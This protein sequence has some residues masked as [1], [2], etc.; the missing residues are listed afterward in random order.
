MGRL[1][2]L[3][4]QVAAVETYCR[5]NGFTPKYFHTDVT[6]KYEYSILSRVKWE[7]HCRYELKEVS[8]PYFEYVPL[9]IVNQNTRFTPPTYLQSEKYFDESIARELYAIPRGLVSYITRRYPDIHD[10]ISLHVRR[11]DYV[12]QPNYH[13]TCPLEYYRK[14]AELFPNQ[15]F[16]VFSDDHDWCRKNLTGIDW[17]FG[18]GYTDDEELYMMSLCKGHIIANSTFSW[19]GAYLNPEKDKLVVAPNTWFGPSYNNINTKDLIPE[20]WIKV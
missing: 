8:H 6:P 20:S 15:K 1:G 16:L 14:A 3:L 12:R 18:V 2:N 19:W 10:R 4:F 9:P 11:G 17:M 13:P 5:K 7:K